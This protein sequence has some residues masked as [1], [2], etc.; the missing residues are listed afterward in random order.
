MGKPWYLHIQKDMHTP[1]AAVWDQ[2]GVTKVCVRLK[3]QK[4]RIL[5]AP[6]QGRTSVSLCYV[7]M[8]KGIVKIL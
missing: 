1:A 8:R 4:C 2:T 6:N 7:G 5:L 3:L